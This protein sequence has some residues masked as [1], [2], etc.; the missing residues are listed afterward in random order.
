MDDFDSIDDILDSL[1]LPGDLADPQESPQG[2]VSR[3]ELSDD[4]EQAPAGQEAEL[5][6]EGEEATPEEREA[7]ILAEL[8]RLKE[9][10]RRWSETDR[11]NQE[12]ANAAERAKQQQAL[13][14]QQRTEAQF[15]REIKAKL[16]EESPE[17]SKALGPF[18]RTLYTRINEAQQRQTEQ[19]QA[20]EAWVYATH[21]VIPESD[22]DQIK[23]LALEMSGVSR[24]EMTAFADE[25][26]RVRH[27]QVRTQTEQQAYVARLEREN[28]ELKGGRPLQA[29]LV[30][31]GQSGAG[32]FGK[33]MDEWSIDDI[34]DFAAQGFDRVAAG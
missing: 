19:E 16:D 22:F 23:D 7:A 4:P 3:S 31:A 17:V 21:R 30:D 6:S 25:R 10:E 32:S 20:I 29:D 34:V 28:A 15:L 9:V 26:I 12:A 2:Q 33:P 14:R 27:D 18:V 5:E 11:A 1:D 8:E 24:D 13:E